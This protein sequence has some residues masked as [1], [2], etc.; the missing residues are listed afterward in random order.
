MWFINNKFSLKIN[1]KNKLIVEN[2]LNISYKPKGKWRFSNYY[3]FLFFNSKIIRGLLKILKFDFP[4]FHKFYYN[5]KE[6]IFI[7][8]FARTI[9]KFFISYF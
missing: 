1:Q 9:K 3:A 4:I 6:N 2:I 7:K 5:H 8:I